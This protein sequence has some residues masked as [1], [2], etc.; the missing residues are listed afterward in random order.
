MASAHFSS[1]ACLTLNETERSVYAGIDIGTSVLGLSGA[2]YQ[3]LTWRSFLKGRPKYALLG[4]GEPGRPTDVKR[5]SVATNPSVIFCLAA[6]DILSCIAVF[7]KSVELIAI[8]RPNVQ[9]PDE[10]VY[11]HKEYYVYFD[12]PISII[13]VFAYVSSFMWTFC[14]ALDIFF[15]LK[16]RC[17]PVFAY[18]VLCWG[19]AA[20]ITAFRVVVIQLTNINPPVLVNTL[21]SGGHNC[22]LAPAVSSANYLAFYIPIVFVML[23]CPVLFLSSLPLIRNMQISNA[24]ML[25]D[26]QRKLYYAVARKFF[27]IVLFFWICWIF[28]VINGLYFL[29]KRSSKG[30]SPFVFYVLEA[31]T[32]PMQGFFNAFVFGQH[33]QVKQAFYRYRW[34]SEERQRAVRASLLS[35]SS[36][37]F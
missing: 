7:A 2:L 6:A 34:D 11:L 3:V 17:I 32:N 36:Q 15:Q 26:Q 24:R 14:Y 25:T 22:I 33:Q 37:T 8:S 10:C 9:L 13:G 31:L 30:D 5:F 21:C 35:D 18:H 19:T 16:R 29:V 12:T 27:F 20:V 28:N 4:A 1:Q 23:A